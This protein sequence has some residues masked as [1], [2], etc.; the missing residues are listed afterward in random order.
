MRWPPDVRYRPPRFLFRR[1]ELLAM[2]PGG[3]S[4][5]EIGSA[6]LALAAELL[7]RFDRGT[8]VELDESSRVFH[9][10]LP[11]ERRNRLSVVVGPFEHVDLADRFECVVCCEVLEHV[12]DDRAFL[13][14]IRSLLVPGGVLALSVPSRMKYWTVHD[15]LVG[16]HRR[17]ERDHLADLLQTTGF[18]EVEIRSYGF[19]WVNLLRLPRLAVARGQAAERSGWDRQR[20]TVE[21]NQRQIPHR[22]ATSPLRFLTRP[23]L[24]APLAVIS[25]LFAGLDL[26]DGYVVTAVRR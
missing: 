8:V 4:F 20:R 15:E 18:C 23:A 12:E 17:Y 11:P 9:A 14:R 26:S 7:D 2:I 6:D 21:S 19:P 3:G 13:E 16:H 5:C 24:I 25:R 22:L 10:G 1:F